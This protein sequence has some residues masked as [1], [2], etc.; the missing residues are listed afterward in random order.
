MR[1]TSK[2][3]LSGWNAD[4]ITQPED[5]LV[6]LVLEGLGIDIKESVR[7]SQASFNQVFM[8]LGWDQAVEVLVVPLLLLASLGVLHNH[9][10]L[11]FIDLEQLNSVLD[12]DFTL[13]D[14]LFDEAISLVEVLNEVVVGVEDGK[15]GVVPG[16]FAIEIVPVPDMLR[17]EEVV[18]LNL[19]VERLGWDV[20]V[21]LSEA[22]VV[23]P[24]VHLVHRRTP[25]GVVLAD[26]KGGL[27]VD[28]GILE[29][30]D[31]FEVILLTHG[32]DQ[33]IVLDFATVSEFDL[34][35]L[36]VELADTHTLG[37]GII[38]VDGHLGK[39]GVLRL[40]GS[41]IRR[42]ATCPAHRCFASRTAG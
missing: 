2:E 38:V 21:G 7:G 28:P 27:S 17:Q 10:L 14:L 5:V 19:T 25:G 9:S 18:A 30:L 6:L 34:V 31:A 12:V 1:E 24:T 15:A 41:K 8:W 39:G 3:G 36:G 16:E 13:S 4:H 29:A 42:G 35:C 37:M 23:M 22:E 33:V 11:V 26:E 40:G 20:E 32:N